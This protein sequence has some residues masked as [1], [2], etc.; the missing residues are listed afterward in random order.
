MIIDD[1]FK[2]RIS[3]ARRCVKLT[4]GD[5]A[6][7]VGV[8]RRQIAAY[9]AGN[10]KPREKVLIKLAAALG[11]TAEWLSMGIGDSPDFRNIK[12]TITVHEIPIYT[13]I[14]ISFLNS[15]NNISPIGFIAAPSNASEK[16]FALE[17]RGNSMISPDGNG[18]FDGMIITFE[19]NDK[20]D[21][22]DLVL[23][24]GAMKL[25]STFRQ[26]IIDQGEWYLSPLNEFYPTIKFTK[27][28]KIIGVAIHAQY[29]IPKQSFVKNNI[30]GSIRENLTNTELTTDIDSISG[31]KLNK[32][33][34]ILQQLLNKYDQEKK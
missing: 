2:S 1:N 12:N 3:L 20:I 4:Q 21:S 16:A 6:K 31:K 26:L 32:I 15:S 19:P 11:T 27:E 9:E 24:D 13:H 5:L 28:M 17:L 25:G 23:V 33:Y 8:V 22:G 29:Y 14:Q 7:K 10:S 34:S 30:N 18:F